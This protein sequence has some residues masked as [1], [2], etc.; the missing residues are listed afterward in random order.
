[1]S[2]LF[3][4]N[5]FNSP[6]NSSILQQAPFVGRANFG[7]FLNSLSLTRTAVEIGTH[8]GGFA[9]TLRDTWHGVSLYTIDPYT[10]GYDSGDPVSY[11]NREADYEEASRL[12]LTPFPDS[13]TEDIPKVY[14]LR[15]TSEQVAKSFDAHCLD[16]VYVDGCHKRQSVAFDIYTWW[17]KVAKGGILAGHDFLCPNEEKGGHGQ[18]IQPVVL[19][20]ALINSLTVYLVLEKDNSPWSW[21][22]VKGESGEEDT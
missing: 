6:R 16:F 2:E 13:L 12:L 17:R 18:N 11:G 1:M 10:S 4:R 14:I 20:F 5:I 22:C 21:Y 7:R 19:E 15:D 8:R 9:K 3:N